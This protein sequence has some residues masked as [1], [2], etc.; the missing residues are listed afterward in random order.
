MTP[1]T[2]AAVATPKR[3]IGYVISKEGVTMEAVG[4]P[5]E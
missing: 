4:G 1:T 5:R 2:A 3:R